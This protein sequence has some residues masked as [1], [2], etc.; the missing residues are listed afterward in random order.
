VIDLQNDAMRPE[1]KIAG[2]HNDISGMLEILPRCSDFIAEARKLRVKVGLELFVGAGPAAVA[3]LAGRRLAPG[4]AMDTKGQATT[5][6]K[7]ALASG[8][9]TA[10]GRQKGYGLS[11][12]AE[13]LTADLTGSP[14]ARNSHGHRNVTGGVG[15]FVLAIE[16][17]FFIDRRSFE[18]AVETLC[19]H[20]KMTPPSVPGG[21]V[22]LPGELGWRTYERRM[23]EGISLP[24]AL[25]DELRQLAER[26]GV[27]LLV[28]TRAP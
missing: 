28:T 10:I 6:P 4:L 13:A 26:L 8:I 22:F 21:E 5:D 1:G 15:H 9:L 3:A 19:S 2:A 27:P 14:V 12:A 17:E 11:V 7:A 16:P 23:R 18:T 20:I 24:T 25:V